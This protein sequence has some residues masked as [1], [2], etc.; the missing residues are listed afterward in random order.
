MMSAKHTSGPWVAGQYGVRDSGG[1]ICKL[2]WP[3]LYEGQD[4]RYWREIAERQA[5][6]RLIAAAPDLLEALCAA[7]KTATFEEHQFRTWH[8]QA[9]SAISKAIGATHE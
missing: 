4:E 8:E 5:D 9:R 3:H 2:H 1:Y 6:A 7:L